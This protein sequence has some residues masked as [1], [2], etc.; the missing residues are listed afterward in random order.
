MS[1]SD[2]PGKTGGPWMAPMTDRIRSNLEL[3]TGINQIVARAAQAM[4]ARQSAVLAEA[5]SDMT[6]LMRTSMPN[7]NDPTAPSRSYAAY[8]QSMVQRG[9][10]QLTFSVETIAEMS[11]SA[12]TLA[13]KRVQAGEAAETDVAPPRHTPR[14]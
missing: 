14:K 1:H 8:V 11:S 13:S 2:E 7:P 10:D 5:I 9:M 12:L 4:S 6:T 3:M